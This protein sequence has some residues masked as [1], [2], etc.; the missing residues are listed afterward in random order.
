[1]ACDPAIVNANH[2]HAKISANADPAYS[3]LGL[4]G[5]GRKNLA[6]RHDLCGAFKVPTLRYVARTAPYFHNGSFDNLRDVV[7]FHVRHDTDPGLW[8]P[9]IG[10][11]HPEVRRPARTRPERRQRERGS[12]RP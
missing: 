3:D 2:S 7:D 9:E 5:P 6:A 12:L 1:M 11:G 10:D 4:C 8:Y